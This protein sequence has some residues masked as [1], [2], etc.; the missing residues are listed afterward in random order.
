MKYESVYE[1]IVANTAEP[2][3]DQACWP[4]TGGLN[5]A[6]YGRL[7]RREG[8]RMVKDLAHRE[9]F[10][11]FIPDIELALDDDPFGPFVVLPG[12][13]LTYND[14]IEHLCFNR[15]CCNPDHHVVLSRAENTSSMQARKKLLRS[16]S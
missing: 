2:E 6:N 5:N 16:L 14:T 10:K 13:E 11:A 12:E 7:S 8:D 4:W 15:R 9:M 3:N 1:R